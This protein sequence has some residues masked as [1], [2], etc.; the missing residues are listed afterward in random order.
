[1]PAKNHE[2]K[3]VSS[4]MNLTDQELQIQQNVG[5]RIREL[6]KSR[7]L[8]TV[9][10]AR[11][12]GISQSQLSKIE[13]GKATIS[14]R[15]LDS[16]CRVLERPLS[17][18]FQSEQEIPRVLG[19]LNTVA[20]PESEGINWFAEEIR[21]RSGGRISLIPLSASQ[22]GPPADQLE[23]L[24]EGVIDLFIEDLA[25]YQDYVSEL[26]VFSLPYVF[27]DSKHLSAFL[28]TP[29]FREELCEDVRRYNFRFIN[30][31]WNWMRGGEWVLVS[32]EPI[33]SPEQVR[34]RRVRIYESRVLYRFWE[35]MGAE[36]V[37]VSW[38]EV[39]DALRRGDVDVV[40]TR[41]AHIYP[42]GFSKYARYITLL[43]D[44]CSVLA[45]TVN[46][47]KYRVLPPSLQEALHQASDVAGEFFSRHVRESEKENELL[48]ISRYQ[49]AYLKVDLAPWQQRAAR[50]VNVLIESGE[51]PAR[52][53]REIRAAG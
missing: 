42:L 29:Y 40:P 15:N 2:S 27:A 33:F 18:L 5:S 53:E 52:V 3:R 22:L 39:R 20:G 30:E 13:T 14:I 9:E 12:A 44:V 6:R 47:S 24:R 4:A 19:T 17:Y 23:Q 37:V 35:E 43:G 36:P 1:M 10:L 49:A 41:K 21:R 28:A 8:N 45:V 32:K 7:R 48:N 38:P 25:H 50:I 46:E 34:G 31:G 51:L 11:L 16:L 26:G